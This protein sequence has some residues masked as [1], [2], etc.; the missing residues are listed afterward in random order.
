MGDEMDRRTAS[1]YELLQI[2]G[3]EMPAVQAA[4]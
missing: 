4:T 2:G 3:D 1:I